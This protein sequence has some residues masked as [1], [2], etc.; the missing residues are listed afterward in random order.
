MQQKT[1]W[2][3]V[4]ASCHFLG[5]RQIGRVM[6]AETDSHVEARSM[7][8]MWCLEGVQIGLTRLR[9][10]LAWRVSCSVLVGL[11]SFLIFAE[12]GTSPVFLLVQIP[13]AD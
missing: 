5:L 9:E 8:D 7:E 6:S 4:L 2:W 1:L 3:Y 11:L 13:P 12:R 10:R